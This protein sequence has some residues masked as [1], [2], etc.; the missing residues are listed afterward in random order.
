MQGCD[1]P[2][3][4]K[5]TRLTAKIDSVID[6]MAD[7]SIHI[8][9]QRSELV[10]NGKS[11]SIKD[12]SIF[13]SNNVVKSYLLIGNSPDGEHG[14]AGT[15]KSLEIVE[16]SDT[17]NSKK[18]LNSQ[19]NFRFNTEENGGIFKN[20]L[21]SSNEELRVPKIGWFPQPNILTRI[22]VHSL[23]DKNKLEPHCY[24]Y[25]EARGECNL[26]SLRFSSALS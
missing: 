16:L 3:H 25:S 14:W 22:P 4:T 23:F 5:R 1:F 6:E 12:E 10:I 24:L 7:I 15:I 11:E 21:A 9:K 20:Q 8:G 19:R 18:L 13:S 17:K 2:N 26:S